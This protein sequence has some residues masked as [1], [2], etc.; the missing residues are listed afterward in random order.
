[1]KQ[2]YRLAPLARCSSSVWFGLRFNTDVA[3]EGCGKGEGRG[4]KKPSILPFGSAA[5]IV[6]DIPGSPQPVFGHR[7]LPDQLSHGDPPQAAGHC[8]L[9]SFL[10]SDC[11]TPPAL[12]A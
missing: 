8:R 12:L 3:R 1:M 7:V 5:E 11:S 10:L 9:D 6:L 4:R 2:T